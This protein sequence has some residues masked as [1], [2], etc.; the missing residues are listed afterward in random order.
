MTAI[1][2]IKNLKK[3]FL[4]ERKSLFNPENKFLHAMND[5]NFVLN[6]GESLGIVGE[7]GCGKSTLARLVMQLIKPTSGSILYKGVDLSKLSKSELKDARKTMQMIFQNP[8]SSLD[9]KKRIIEL[10]VEPLEIYNL[11]TKE[12]REAMAME[13]LKNV[14]LHESLAYRYPHEFSGGQA[15][16][17]NIARALMLKPEIIICDEPVSALDV[18]IQA[19]VINLLIDLQKQF[20]L[21][22]IFISHDLSIVRYFCDRMLV[23]NGGKIVESGNAEDVYNNPQHEYTK[24]LLA[25]K[26]VI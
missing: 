16:R 4:I 17:I 19:Q 18:S 15:Q 13:M 6:K 24:K 23:M 10:L 11:H 2:E 22:Y 21:S 8:L 1:L 20:N 3:D 25:A 5:V 12:E 26:K 9:P 14:G 7:S